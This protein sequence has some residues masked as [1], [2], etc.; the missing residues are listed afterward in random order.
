MQQG[1]KS[2]G[3]YS[4]NCLNVLTRYI[5]P[6]LEP[7]ERQ[8]FRFVTCDP[9]QEALAFVAG[10]AALAKKH[11]GKHDQGTQHS[12]DGDDSFSLEPHMAMMG[13]LPGSASGHSVGLRRCELT[14]LD[15]AR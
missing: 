2:V 3:A 8:N 13:V 12:D 15:W 4:A 14:P 6:D 9:L 7:V 10:A 5:S 1:R 11:D